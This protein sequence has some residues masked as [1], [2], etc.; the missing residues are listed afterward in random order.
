MIWRLLIAIA[1]AVYLAVGFVWGA[2]RLL[3]DRAMFIHERFYK[4]RWLYFWYALTYGFWGVVCVVGWVIVRLLDL[5]F[6][7]PAKPETPPIVLDG[8]KD[9]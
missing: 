5:F 3:E 8:G 6:R 4:R 1:A 7:T 9:E 2:P